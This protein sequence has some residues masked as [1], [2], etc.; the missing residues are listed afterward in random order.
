MKNVLYLAYWGVEDGLTVSVIF[1]HLKLIEQN[2]QVNKIIFV[3]IERDEVSGQLGKD[4]F[5]TNKIIHV[6]LR[7]RNI[8]PN[9]LNKFNDFFL[10]PK[11]L[12]R[13][14][15]LY[16]IDLAITHGMVSGSLLHLVCPK[17]KIPY[18]VFSEPHSAYMLESGVWSKRDPRYIFQRKWEHE[19]IHT[20]SGLFSV[21]KNYINVL[22]KSYDKDIISKVRLAA[23]AVDLNLFKFDNVQRE[24]VRKSL[25]INPS[26]VVGIYVGKFGGI[27]LKDE[28]FQI[29]RLAN[30]VFEN[31]TLIILSPQNLEE[32]VEVT[33]LEEPFEGLDYRILKVRHH[34]VPNYLSASDFGYS[35]QNPKPSNLFLCPLKNGEYWASGLPIYS[36]DDVG[37]DTTLIKNGNNLGVIFKLNDVE[38]YLNAYQNIKRIL[39]QRSNRLNNEA[40]NAAEMNRNIGDIKDIYDHLF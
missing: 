10:F 18:Y 31:F 35:M 27:Y 38:S 4:N 7:S 12:R 24:N 8:S 21:T 6:G 5:E 14:V 22:S 17:L 26:N 25:G 32:I 30:K 39:E 29:F 2:S 40:K 20:A 23:N 16:K 1:P 15:K 19:Q 28:A 34:E 11:K 33:G 37:D 9:V 3:T 13:I 36:I